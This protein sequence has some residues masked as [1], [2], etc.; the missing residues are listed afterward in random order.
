MERRAKMGTAVLAIV[1]VLAVLV[2]AWAQTTAKTA[3]PAK[4]AAAEPAKLAV[5]NLNT[6]TVDQLAELKGVGP[7]VAEA[8]VKHREANGP[9]KKPEDLMNVKG[10]GQKLFD[11]NKERIVVK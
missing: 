8:I 7:K 10:I 9:F 5:V 2:P 1:F 11:A 3:E 6:A 4:A